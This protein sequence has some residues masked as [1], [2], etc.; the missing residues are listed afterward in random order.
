M[1]SSRWNSRPAKSRDACRPCGCH[2]VGRVGHCRLWRCSVRVPTNQIAQ[3]DLTVV[4][5]VTWFDLWFLSGVVGCLYT[6]VVIVRVVIVRIC[7]RATNRSFG[8]IRSIRLFLC[9]SVLIAFMQ[10]ICRLL[11]VPDKFLETAVGRWRDRCLY[12]GVECAAVGA[13]QQRLVR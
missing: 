9:L 8:S 10:Q 6:T 5:V 1:S 13:R 3:V 12:L 2:C 4:I 11:N 7:S